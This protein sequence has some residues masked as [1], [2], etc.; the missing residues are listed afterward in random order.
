MQWYKIDITNV[1]CP[2][3]YEFKE[4]FEF[5]VSGSFC[6]TKVH[7]VGPLVPS[8][9]DFGWY[10]AHEFQSQGG[11]IVACPL[12]LLMCNDPQNH[13]LLPGPGIKSGSLTLEVSTI[14]LCQPDP[15]KPA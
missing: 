3:I 9:S 2:K 5:Q 13:L 15:A 10:S 8:V 14:P 1:I 11:S 4:Q 7:F 6:W 12:L